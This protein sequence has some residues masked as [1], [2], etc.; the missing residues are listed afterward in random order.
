M[1]PK[2]VEHPAFNVVGLSTRHQYVE[3][4]PVLPPGE[5]PELAEFLKSWKPRHP[6]DPRSGMEGE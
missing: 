3:L 5:E 4:H 6:F 2:F 1:Q